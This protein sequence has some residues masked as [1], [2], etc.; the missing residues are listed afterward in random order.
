MNNE[1]IKK[2]SKGTTEGE[3][4]SLPL[5]GKKRLES[6][7]IG[8]DT[9]EKSM[10][11]REH[12]TLL[13]EDGLSKKWWQTGWITI[14]KQGIYFLVQKYCAEGSNIQIKIIQKLEKTLF[15]NLSTAERLSM[16]NIKPWNRRGKDWQS[17]NAKFINF[18]TAK[19]WHN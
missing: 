1:K 3:W 8:Q 6:Q 2:K 16:R 17:N 13:G 5:G 4:D 9:D 7:E 15:E 14:K 10:W 11:P 18:W 12:V 19:E